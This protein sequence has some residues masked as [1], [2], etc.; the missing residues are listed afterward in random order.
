LLEEKHKLANDALDKFFV[1]NGVIRISE[2]RPSEYLMYINNEK[3]FEGNIFFDYNESKSGNIDEPAII[4]IKKG[5]M[6]NGAIEEM[7]RNQT[8]P[9]MSL[10]K[11]MRQGWKALKRFT[12][13]RLALRMR[14]K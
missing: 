4:R 11:R 10:T 3:H 7:E 1:E 12:I 14:K 8:V 5:I 9:K 13:I 2:Q 6:K